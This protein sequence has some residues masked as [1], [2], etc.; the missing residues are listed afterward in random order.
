ML[1]IIPFAYSQA[2]I[3]LTLALNP[4]TDQTETLDMTISGTILD[5]SSNPV[6][7]NYVEI[8]VDGAVMD[9]Q[10]RNQT[11][12]KYID[13]SFNG[14]KENVSL[15]SSGLSLIQEANLVEYN[16]GDGSDGNLR[17]NT[18]FNINSVA[19]VNKIFSG[20]F[21]TT[22]QKGSTLQGVPICLYNESCTGNF[23][24]I[25]EGDEIIIIEM[26]YDEGIVYKDLFSPDL[27]TTTGRYEINRVKSKPSMNMIVLEKPLQNAYDVQRRDVIMQK[28][29]N[30][31][32]VNVKN[33]G[34]ITADKWDG[35]KGG[36][37]IFRARNLSIEKDASINATALGYRGGVYGLGEGIMETQYNGGS[38]FAEDGGGS[39]PGGGGSHG[40]IGKKGLL[41]YGYPDLSK[42]YLGAGGGMLEYFTKRGGAGGGIIMIYAD[43]V[44][45]AGSIESDGEALWTGGAGGSIL[46]TAKSV[47]GHGSIT[48]TG[49]NVEGHEGG[50]G[51]IRININST[52]NLETAPQRYRNGAVGNGYIM[53]DVYDATGP[54]RWLNA[55][56]T[57]LKDTGTSVKFQIRSCNN[58]G[59]SDR[60]FSGPLGTGSFY[61][62]TYADLDIEKGRYFQYKLFLE[63]DKSRNRTP[64]ITSFNVTYEGLFTNSE[65]KYS[66][67]AAAPEFGSHNIEARTSYMNMTGFKSLNFDTLPVASDTLA[68]SVNDVALNSTAVE[69]GKS[70]MIN[71]SVSDGVRVISVYARIKDSEGN[72]VRVLQMTD[73]NK[74]GIYNSTWDTY[75]NNSQPATIGIYFI[76]ILATDLAGNQQESLN[77]ASVA[78]ISSS[79]AS[80]SFIKML[81]ITGPVTLNARNETDAMLTFSAAAN[82]SNQSASIVRYSKNIKSQNGNLVHLKTIEATFSQ[83]LTALLVPGTIEIRYRD[84]E[85]STAGI[86][87]SSLRIYKWDGI[88]W[89]PASSTLDTGANTVSSSFTEPGIYSLFGSQIVAQEEPEPET[90]PIDTPSGG[91]SGSGSGGGSGSSG[92]GSGVSISAS[93]TQFQKIQTMYSSRDNHVQIATPGIAIK[94]LIIRLSSTKAVTVKASSIA[95]PSVSSTPIAAVFSYID[96]T[97]QGLDDSDIRAAEILFIVNTSWIDEKN[98]GD[99]EMLRYHDGD[100]QHLNTTLVA[101]GTTTNTYKAQTP[102]FSIFAIA[103]YPKAKPVI[104]GA[105][106]S[107]TS[108]E[109]QQNNT[110]AVT[111]RIT[112]SFSLDNTSIIVL[113]AIIILII[114]SVILARRF[115]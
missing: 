96:V 8:K 59:C 29:P 58:A 44:F 36:I 37:I 103:G 6:A 89:I 35:E 54:A 53:S 111:G 55:S 69:S 62:G 114:I 106:Q 86:I 27:M 64:Y 50:S 22:L 52:S 98:I 48:A 5:Q 77:T 90:P 102:G 18:T 110:N 61:S 51:I 19:P 26:Q 97:P 82:I 41:L 17:I 24:G 13:S 3:D 1:V 70:L 33:G 9:S 31:N 20:K 104:A 10:L 84:A 12:L 66:F 75:K 93:A 2:G 49:G 87:E 47:A 7:N 94:E 71:A 65:G 78:L 56:W 73:P 21:G 76:D 68:P 91:S 16:S 23:G 100:W 85:H 34:M 4:S 113:V 74:D 80:G 60:E 39:N 105:N 101:Q 46:I 42:I 115:G 107:T 108:N 63:P 28:I 72:Q 57:G 88:Q 11:K 40:T 43:S 112:D 81:N 38:P 79:S 45:V 15:V 14:I 92:S 67:V 95:V 32:I 99:I 30:F 25:E 109:T 83:N